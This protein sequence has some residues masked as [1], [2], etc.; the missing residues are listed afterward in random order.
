MIYSEAGDYKN[1]LDCFSKALALNMLPK[2]SVKLAIN[3]TNIGRI[4]VKTG[5]YDIA[6]TSLKQAEN[7][8]I[9][10][11]DSMD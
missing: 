4:R 6:E 5:S 11:T 8:F 1:S 10:Y 2:D 7:I 3:L 9:I